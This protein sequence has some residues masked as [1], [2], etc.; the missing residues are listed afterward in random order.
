M[1]ART[2]LATPWSDFTLEEVALF[3]RFTY[4]P[5]DCSAAN[6]QKAAAHLPRLLQLAHQLGASRMVDALVQQVADATTSVD[7]LVRFSNAADACQLDGARQKCMRALR[8]VLK[9]PSTVSVADAKALL[10]LPSEEDSAEL[11]GVLLT[12]HSTTGDFEWQVPNFSREAS[13]LRS[14]GFF[15]VGAKWRL[16]VD[17]KGYGE[18][19]GTHLSLFLRCCS[20]D[21]LPLKTDVVFTVYGKESVVTARCFQYVE[22]ENWGAPKLVSLE[23]LRDEAYGYL[24][25][26]TLR[27]A[28]KIT[29]RSD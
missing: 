13:R 29:K 27:V 3:L 8:R 5:Q 10:A 22:P 19:A 12:A 4:S 14:P 2:E 16:R 7:L 9:G 20:E 15:A 21:G 17:P 11:I 24:V 28:V 26:D 25:D 6:L 23:R 18:G 1:Q